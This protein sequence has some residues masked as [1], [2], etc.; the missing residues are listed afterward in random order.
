MTI[1]V[2]SCYHWKISWKC[3]HRYSIEGDE[4]SPKLARL[5]KSNTPSALSQSNRSAQRQLKVARS[6]GE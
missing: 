6:D 2:Q 1:S 3:T 4:I 5:H